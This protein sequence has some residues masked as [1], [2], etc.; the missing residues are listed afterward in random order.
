MNFIYLSVAS[1]KKK[2]RRRKT[3]FHQI[4]ANEIIKIKAICVTWDSLKYVPIQINLL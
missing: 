1:R 2:K 3:N 4:S